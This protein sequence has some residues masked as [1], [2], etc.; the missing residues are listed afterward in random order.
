[1]TFLGLAAR[2]LLRNKVRTSLTVLGV[3]IAIVTFLLLRTVVS[4]WTASADFAAKDRVVTRHKVTFIMLLP[5]RYIDKVRAAPDVKAA[6]FA[7]WFGGRVPGNDREF[8]ATLAVDP[9]SYF[10][11]MSEFVVD[12]AERA[13]F[14]ED[15]SGAVVGDV[16]AQKFGWKPGDRVTLESP[17][18]PAAPDKPWTFTIRGVYTATQ[19]SADR[20]TFLFHWDYL[21]ETLPPRRKDEIGWVMTRVSDASRTA[22]VGLALDRMFDDE[23]VQTL[24]QD[25]ASF[26]ASFLAGISAVLSAIDAVSVAILAIMMLVLGNTIAMGVRER[27]SE[28]GAMRA[29]GFLPKHI[30]YFVLGEAAVLGAVGGIVG[31]GLGFPIIEKGLG[32][33]LEE[34]MGA[35]FPY[36]RVPPVWIGAALVLSVALGVGASLLPA[37]AAMRLRVT[38]ALRRIA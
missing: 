3:A 34:N 25:E 9:K 16:L 10:D 13:A 26:N 21:N 5:R 20:S 18:Y 17:I 8:F 15:R 33:W 19:R 31:V 23:E 4:A 24:S 6:S 1:M 37:R 27:T 2:N 29:I 14:F 36:F 11:V 38:D 32:R 35:F 28:Y 7:N 12:D 22:A 30:A